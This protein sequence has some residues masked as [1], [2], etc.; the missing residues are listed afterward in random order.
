MKY[1][2]DTRADC[3]IWRHNGGSGSLPPWLHAGRRAQLC[4]HTAVAGTS[5]PRMH[6][7]L[8]VCRA[9]GHAALPVLRYPGGTPAVQE[10]HLQDDG[11][12]G[13]VEELD[14]VGLGAVG[15]ARPLGP[16]GQLHAE[17]LRY[18]SAV[19]C[20]T[21]RTMCSGPKSPLVMMAGRPAAARCG[22]R[23]A[24]VQFGTQLPGS[25]T[26]GSRPP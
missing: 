1:R 22:L 26:P 8:H 21:A 10:R 3:S 15:A 18:G 14:G 12:V 13:G 4:G 19:R 24:C 5:S 16:D 6:Q 23:A 20:G 2:L 11:H 17:T 7:P 25:C 9:D